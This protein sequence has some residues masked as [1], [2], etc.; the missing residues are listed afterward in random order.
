MP[1]HDA[2]PLSEL[3]EERFY[4]LYTQV[5]CRTVAPPAAVA[6][7]AHRHARLVLPCHISPMLST[8]S[9]TD[10][11]VAMEDSCAPMED[12]GV[13]TEEEDQSAFQVWF[14]LMCHWAPCRSLSTRSV[15]SCVRKD[16]E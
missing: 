6:F 9:V 16:Y 12:S 10:K 1:A 13:P 2:I 3:S 8:P 11:S 7:V 15:S 5:Q 14:D 4:A